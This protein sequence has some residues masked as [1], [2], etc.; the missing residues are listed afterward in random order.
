LLLS[1][2]KKREPFFFFFFFFSVAL[3]SRPEDPEWAAPGFPS[4]AFF[5]SLSPIVLPSKRQ[6]FE[7]RRPNQSPSPNAVLSK[8][9]FFVV[10]SL[11]ARAEISTSVSST[12]AYQVPMT[13][14]F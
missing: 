6:S 4:A 2:G 9:K 14:A 10:F 8:P 11:A 1:D 3:I 12:G 5:P 13:V 7:S